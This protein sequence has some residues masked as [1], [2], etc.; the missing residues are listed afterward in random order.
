MIT[1]MEEVKLHTRQSQG[2]IYIFVSSIARPEKEHLGNDKR[3]LNNKC[4]EMT[5]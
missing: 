3:W 2:Y 4:T 5:N 1:C